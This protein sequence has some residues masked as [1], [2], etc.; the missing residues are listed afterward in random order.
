[1]RFLQENSHTLWASVCCCLLDLATL[2]YRWDQLWP[3]P[4]SGA[5]KPWDPNTKHTKST[6]CVTRFSHV[7]SFP[8]W[9]T[10]SACLCTNGSI[11]CAIIITLSLCCRSVF[12][13]ARQCR[14]AEPLSTCL[15]E[16]SHSPPLSRLT[17]S[18][19]YSHPIPS[20]RH[21]T[22]CM[23]TYARLRNREDGSGVL[24]IKE[25][26][27]T[28]VTLSVLMPLRPLFSSNYLYFCCLCYNQS[29]LDML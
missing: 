11:R 21:T 24:G 29:C 4:P 2:A 23:G 25:N 18:I 8:H 6:Q 28:G 13:C 5:L 12:V 9:K 3:Q 16:S 20:P 14:G 27:K 15:W 1:M 26:I 22:T 7:L 19:H 17:I 10:H